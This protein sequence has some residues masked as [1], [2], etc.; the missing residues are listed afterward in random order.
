MNHLIQSVCIANEEPNFVGRHKREM[1]TKLE[2]SSMLIVVYPSTDGKSCEMTFAKDVFDHRDYAV[3]Q[4]HPDG[5]LWTDWNYHEWDIDLP[6]SMKID[7]QTVCAIQNIQSAEKQWR[8]EHDIH[9]CC[10][11]RCVVRKD[12]WLYCNAATC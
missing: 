12:G 5:I 4:K 11:V 3:A 10:E 2:S 9:S 6:C 7:R 8:E 1:V